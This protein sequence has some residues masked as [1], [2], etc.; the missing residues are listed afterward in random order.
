MPRKQV[1]RRTTA[2]SGARASRRMHSAPCRVP[3]TL[4]PDAQTTLAKA[5]PYRALQGGV[6]QA[7]ELELLARLVREVEHGI[8]Q[9][10]R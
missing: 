1:R 2:D 8:E 4:N 3:K 5:R 9:L 6:K 10:E 7:F